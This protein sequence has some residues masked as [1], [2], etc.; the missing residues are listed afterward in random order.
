MTAQLAQLPTLVARTR[1]LRDPV[2]P[3][4]LLGPDGFAW[5]RDGVGF[6]TAG[7][8][9]EMP[10]DAVESALATIEVD[11]AVT[12]PGT[13]AIAVG[14]LPF[15]PGP[16]R[17]VIPARVVGRAADGRTWVTEL[18]PEPTQSRREGPEP[19]TTRIRRVQDRATWR[20]AVQR[21]LDAIDAGTVAKVVLARE[22]VI[23]ADAPFDRITVV[24]RLRDLEPGCYVFAAGAFVGAS[25]ELLVQ[26]R[27]FHVLSRPMAGTVAVADA[28][29]LAHLAGS[30]KLGEEHRLVVDAVVAELARHCELPPAVSGPIPAPIGELAHLVT[31]VRGRLREPAASALTLARALHPTPAVGGT[32]IDAALALIDELEPRGRGGY[33]GPVGWIDGRGDGE[34]AVALRGAELEGNT[35]RLHA[36]AGIVAGSEPDE[37]WAETEAKLVPMLRA[38]TTR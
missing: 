33:A 32:P 4:D 3:F 5:W 16:G 20:A 9:A 27:G 7:T 23:E 29:G 13:G 38:L 37:E 26:R 24:R 18:R 21:A 22:V 1:L 28:A 14:A 25:P 6:V 12:V 30:A 35:A 10:A 34:I 17:F 15:A 19:T 36:G 11:D 8:V 31:E 2:D